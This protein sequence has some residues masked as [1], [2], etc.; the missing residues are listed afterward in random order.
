MMVDAHLLTARTLAADDMMARAGVV[1]AITSS[2]ARNKTKPGGSSAAQSARTCGGGL[3]LSTH[4]HGR[5]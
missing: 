1:V 5:E 3:V 2:L 4:R